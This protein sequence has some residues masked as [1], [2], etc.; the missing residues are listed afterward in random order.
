MAEVLG[1]GTGIGRRL[2]T[3]RANLDLP[4][5]MAWIA[6]VLF[7]IVIC[8][9]IFLSPLRKRAGN[10]PSGTERPSIRA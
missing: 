10:H 6:I 5:T 1:G 2:E 8:D 9:G 7:L 4:E 3:A